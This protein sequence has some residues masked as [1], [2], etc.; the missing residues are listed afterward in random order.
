M[1]EGKKERLVWDG[2]DWEERIGVE[3]I[4]R[5]GREGGR[6]TSTAFINE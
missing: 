6:T 3:G 4:R 2:E 5:S 1:W